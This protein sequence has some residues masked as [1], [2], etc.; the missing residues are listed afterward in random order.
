MPHRCLHGSSPESPNIQAS[1]CARER[2][3]GWRRGLLWRSSG[4]STIN[5]P[6]T[7]RE[8]G[9]CTDCHRYIGSRREWEAQ[10]L[11]KFLISHCFRSEPLS[12]YP[13]YTYPLRTRLTLPLAKADAPPNR[14]SC[15]FS[16][17]YRT[18]AGP[19]TGDRNTARAAV[20]AGRQE[21]MRAPLAAPHP[22]GP[23][24]QGSRSRA[25]PQLA[26]E[27]A[28]PHCDIDLGDGELASR[29]SPSRRTVRNE[30]GRQAAG[31]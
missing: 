4:R 21:E 23:Q 2:R 3:A 16:N 28:V 25:G 29:D 10:T 24:G 9:S 27:A 14:P 18:R 20:L 13:P 5:H 11:P 1:T 22:A 26:G 6:S 30:R 19:I 12:C 8:R 7:K 15:W 17:R 31:G